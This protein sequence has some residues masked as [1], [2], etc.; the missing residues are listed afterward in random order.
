MINKTLKLHLIAI[1]FA[2]FGLLSPVAAAGVLAQGTALTRDGT[3]LVFTLALTEKTPFSVY[4][5]DNP[6]RLLVD[7]GE[8][9]LENMPA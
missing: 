1:I 2:A 8:T 5:L 4:T 6:R 3:S 7:L 9:S